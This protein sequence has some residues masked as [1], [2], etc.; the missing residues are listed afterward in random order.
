[1]LFGRTLPAR[2]ASWQRRDA[3]AERVGELA[4]EACVAERPPAIGRRAQRVHEA[5]FECR[6]E[7]VPIGRLAR[8]CAAPEGMVE[9][10]VAHQRICGTV[11]MRAV[12]RPSV[13]G[14]VRHDARAPG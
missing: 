10:M 12:A 2:S 3:P 11:R 1:M 7:Q 13:I 6:L 4:L 5:R 14:R 9:R 8:C